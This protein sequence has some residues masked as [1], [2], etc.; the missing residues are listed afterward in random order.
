MGALVGSSP[1]ELY[2]KSAQNFGFK[3]QEKILLE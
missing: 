2:E 1:Y 3:A